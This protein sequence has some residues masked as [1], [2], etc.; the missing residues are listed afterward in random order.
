M[1]TLEKVYLSGFP[2]LMLFVSI[3]PL[4][5]SR[6]SPSQVSTPVAN[7]VS[8]DGFSCP[9]PRHDVE[10]STTGPSAME[11]LPLMATSIYCA[12]GL[13]WGFMRLGFIYLQEETK[14]Q[15]QLSEIK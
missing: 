11:F 2:F 13:V 5:R 12:I 1:D 4:A 7:C 3:F 9:E 6:S 10:Q 8:T 14:Y 15:G